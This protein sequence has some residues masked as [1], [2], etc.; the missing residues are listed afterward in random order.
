MGIREDLRETLN[1]L[2]GGDIYRLPYDGIKT[3][4]KNH[5]RVVRK[6]GRASQAVANSS[7][8]NTSIKIEIGKMLEEFNSGM[9][10]TLSLQM[11]NM[12]IK[13]KEEEAKSIIHIFP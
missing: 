9:L 2:S 7:S 4:F 3:V 6:K 12:Q 10:Q 11:D 5:S 1:L 13:R 8:S